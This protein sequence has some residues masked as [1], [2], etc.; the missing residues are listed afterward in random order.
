[1]KKTY[2]ILVIFMFATV[3]LMT[4]GCNSEELYG[5]TSFGGEKINIKG[6]L[7]SPKSY[8]GKTIEVEGKIVNECPTGCWFNLDT[9]SGVVY[10]DLN[11]SGMAIPQRVG[12]KAKVKGKVVVKNGNAMIVGEGVKIE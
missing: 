6:V 3:V 12:K 2:M 4:M 5:N 11:P 8:E 9:G 7:A 1:M 10:V